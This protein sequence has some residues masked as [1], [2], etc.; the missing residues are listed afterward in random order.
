MKVKKLIYYN[1]LIKQKK[2]FINNYKFRN[3]E[4]KEVWY[5]FKQISEEPEQ[6]MGAY[7]IS[8]TSTASDILSVLYLTKRS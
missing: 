5:T 7:V 2:Y 6:C 3:K 4:N 8:M 1:T